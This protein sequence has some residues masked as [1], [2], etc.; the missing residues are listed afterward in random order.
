MRF[1]QAWQ[2]DLGS[3]V[4]SKPWWCHERAF[5]VGLSKGLPQ[6]KVKSVGSSVIL[7]DITPPLLTCEQQEN[8]LNLITTTKDQ[9]IISTFSV[10]HQCR[11]SACHQFWWFLPLSPHEEHILPSPAHPSQQTPPPV[12]EQGQ[13]KYNPHKCTTH[14]YAMCMV[15][16]G[17]ICGLS[18]C[19]PTQY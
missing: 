12:A 5:L 6:G 7:H 9:H 8:L 19:L 10:P 4:K 1:L 3:K 17:I 14:H 13:S 2:T 11:G 15:Q 18:V 16:I